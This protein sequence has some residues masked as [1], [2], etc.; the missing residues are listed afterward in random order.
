[1]VQAA[2]SAV[3]R[4][5]TECQLQAVRPYLAFAEIV[6]CNLLRLQRH[7]PLSVHLSPFMMLPNSCVQQQTVCP[8]H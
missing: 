6:T 4:T 7:V 3:F 2:D 1:M 8:D 5:Q